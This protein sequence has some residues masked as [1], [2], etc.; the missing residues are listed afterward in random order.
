MPN[1]IKKR[2]GS[3]KK[4]NTD[5]RSHK[6]LD[7]EIEDCDVEES[8]KENKF[9][10]KTPNGLLDIKK[11]ELSP[12]VKYNKPIPI[13]SPDDNYKHENPRTRSAVKT[14]NI[15]EN[16]EINRKIIMSNSG[17]DSLFGVS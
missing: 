15:L 13:I 16:S 4:D 9:K 2:K 10:N 8:N 5:V 14:K 6:S 7:I 11:A 3:K 1:K 17:K 12:D